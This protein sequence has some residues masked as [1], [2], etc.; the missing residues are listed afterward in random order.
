MRVLIL[1]DGLS[2]KSAKVLLEQ[3]GDEAVI[4]DDNKDISK[5][6]PLG[7]FDLCVISPG[8]PQNHPLAIKY[9]DRLI[10][11][12]DLAFMPQMTRNYK[13]VRY[14]YK[15]VIAVTGTNGKTTVVSSLHEIF[16]R[17]SILC[18]NVGVTA[19]SIVKKMRKKF[20]IVEVSSFQLET[21]PKYFIPDISVILNITQDHLERHKT[22]DEYIECKMRLRGKISIMNWDDPVCRSHG[23]SD[24]LWYSTKEAVRGVYLDKGDII[25]N[26][27]SLY[28]KCPIKRRGKIFSLDHK[29]LY[30]LSRIPHNI[31]NF[32]AV[33]LVCTL[34]GVNK[35][36][37]IRGSEFNKYPHRLEYIGECGGRI[38]YN[39]SKSTNVASCIAACRSFD[40][41]ISLIVGG[42]SKGQNFSELFVDLPGNVKNMFVIGQAT[43][44][45]INSSQGV[46]HLLDIRAC[47]SLEDAVTLALAVDLDECII[48]LSPA[49]ASFDMFEN[50]IHRG[51][52]FKQ[53]AQTF[54]NNNH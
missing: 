50:Y 24:T 22:M 27:G 53:I 42:V 46:K 25:L 45:I 34:M 41:T 39:D 14:G 5:S 3:R 43:E 7:G 51:E 11:E 20:G 52:V 32:L 6:K 8:V 16:G 13:P 49:C 48:L 23:T 38:F 44:E 36:R 33:V 35:G 18:G 21:P 29:K 15:K 1:G 47:K 30:N 31:S 17:K 54:I 12:L 26:I 19:T 28:E 37:I 4:Y 10:S 40:Q 2:G 9:A